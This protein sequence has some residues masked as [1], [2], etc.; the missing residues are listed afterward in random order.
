MIDALIPTFGRPDRL[1]PLAANILEATVNPV[2]VW[3]IVEQDDDG[4]VAEGER[5]M[6]RSGFSNVMCLW[7]EGPRSYAG[8]INTAHRHTDAPWLFTGAD[9]LRFWPG[10]DKA[11]F[12]HDDGRRVIG[13]QD[14][15]NPYVQAMTHATHYLVRRDYLDEVG[16]VIDKGPGSFQNEGYAHQYVD[17]E[18][19]DTARHR[20]EFRP[21]LTSIVEHRHWSVGGME[22]DA[23]SAKAYRDE[24]TDRDLYLSRC[25]LWGGR[26]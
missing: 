10:W 22:P 16:G 9:D 7:N 12:E 4:S 19:V 5:L 1:A 14:L 15:L 26:A 2:T 25:H 17:T 21:C 23:T 3:F 18:F 24:A 11:A 20:G 6:A 13:T 8:A